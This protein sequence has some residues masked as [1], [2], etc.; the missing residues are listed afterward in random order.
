VGEV[1]PKMSSRRG[2]EEG[3]CT[4]MSGKLSSSVPWMVNVCRCLHVGVMKLSGPM[5]CQGGRMRNRLIKGERVARGQGRGKACRPN[6]ARGKKF[7]RTDREQRVVSAKKGKKQESG[8][9][10]LN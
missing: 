4:V 3:G 9:R 1:K 8:E 2:R 6:A 7:R 5:C 10:P